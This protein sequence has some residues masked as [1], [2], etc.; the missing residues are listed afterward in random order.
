NLINDF[1]LSASILLWFNPVAWN[2]YA[3]MRRIQDLS[4]DEQVLKNKST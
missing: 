3:S 2:G 1:A 4:C